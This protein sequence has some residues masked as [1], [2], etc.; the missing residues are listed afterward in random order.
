MRRLLIRR[1]GIMGQEN[2]EK[3]LDRELPHGQTESGLHPIHRNNELQQTK[4]GTC[5]TSHAIWWNGGQTIVTH[6]SRCII[7]EHIL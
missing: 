7:H 5:A 3:A 6:L 1:E 4:R 2:L